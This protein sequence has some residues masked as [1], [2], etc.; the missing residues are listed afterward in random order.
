MYKSSL[1]SVFFAWDTE[2]ASI[3]KVADTYEVKHVNNNKI[4]LKIGPLI[5]I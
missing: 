2:I 3:M 4:V 1:W 5:N